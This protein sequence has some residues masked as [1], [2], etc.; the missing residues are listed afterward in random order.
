MSK[1]LL[2][3]YQQFTQTTALYPKEDE[4]IYLSAGLG[5][6]V[7][8]VLDAYAK[9]YRGDYSPDVL[10]E[11]LGKELGDLFWFISQI[12]NAEGLLLEDLI[13]GNISKLTS[14]KARG[15]IQ[16]SGDDR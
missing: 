14:R 15:V 13:T 2:Q 5:A 11:K 10:R 9:Y 7:G 12:C 4:D 16:G 3:D 8:E 6:E 1:N